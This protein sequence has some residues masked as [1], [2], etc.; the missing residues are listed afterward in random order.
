M[1]KVFI[2]G[3]VSS[4]KEIRDVGQNK[5]FNFSV[6]V[7]NGKDQSGEWKPSSFYDVSVWN[8]R[9]EALARFLSKGTKVAV[10]GRMMP[11]RVHEGKAYQSIEADEV[12]LQGGGSD[13]GQS[14]EPDTAGNGTARYDEPADEIPF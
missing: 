7:S 13:Q 9:G 3:N 1:Q 4:V 10:S 11:A 5:V 2:A 8:K 14:R 6:A 12:T